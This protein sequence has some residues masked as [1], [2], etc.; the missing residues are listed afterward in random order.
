MTSIWAEIEAGADPSVD[1]ALPV[2]EAVFRAIGHILCQWAFFEQHLNQALGRLGS[3]NG[4]IFDERLVSASFK[5][6][7]GAWE[8]LAAP[9][10]RNDGPR[11]HIAKVRKRACDLKDVRD[12]IAHGTWSLGDESITLTTYKYGAEMNMRDHDLDALSLEKIAASIS[13]I[14]AALWKLDRIYSVRYP[15]EQLDPRPVS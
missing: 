14:S 10:F 15:V 3:H 4:A 12:E 9:M 13:E 6:R 1:L 11:G 5:K 8:K 2:P 7:L